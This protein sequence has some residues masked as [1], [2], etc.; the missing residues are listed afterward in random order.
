MIISQLGNLTGVPVDR[1]SVALELRSFVAH[2][3]L[4]HTPTLVSG[5]A[6]LAMLFVIGWRFP[7]SAPGPLIAMIVAGGCVASDIGRAVRDCGGDRTVDLRPAAP[8]ASGSPSRH[9]PRTKPSE[10]QPS[11]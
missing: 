3:D 2:L 4:V 6:V 5:S 1:G 7:R 10:R 9:A 11:L 8:M